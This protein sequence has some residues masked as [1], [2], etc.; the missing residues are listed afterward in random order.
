[1]K[2]KEGYK[3]LKENRLLENNVTIPAAL[4]VASNAIAMIPFN[5]DWSNS[6]YAVYP[7]VDN[8]TH[9]L[10]GY[11]VSQILERL[12]NPLSEKHENIRKIP[13]E[14]FII[15]GSMLLGGFTESYEK[16]AT[17]F[18]NLQM[19]YEPVENSIKDLFVDAAGILSQRYASRKKGI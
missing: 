10:G 13:K 6:I 1:M 4:A 3:W 12:Y 18:S 8:L 2:I 15:G 9:F 14:R 5:G 16:I 17:T 7:E 19:F 11:G